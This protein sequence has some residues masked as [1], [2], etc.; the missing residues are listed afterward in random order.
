MEII[1]RH[2]SPEEFAAY[3]TPIIE[4]SSWKGEFVVLHNTGAPTLA[5]RPDGLTE[6]HIQNLKAYYESL[7][8][9][10]GPHLFVDQKGIWAFSPLTAPGVHSPAWNRISY[11]VEQLGD[12]DREAYDG[13]PGALVKANAIAALAVIH[14]AAGIDSSTLKLH[15]MDPLTTH[16]DCPGKHCAREYDAIKAAVHDYIA[17]RLGG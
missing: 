6:Q 13:G 2:F 7:G 11:G 10:A 15:K 12:Y 1:A 4:A 5:Q 3:A 16:K 8:W 9:H 17:G 14:H